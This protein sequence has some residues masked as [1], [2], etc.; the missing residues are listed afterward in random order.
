MSW[1]CR[2]TAH[3]PTRTISLTTS[4]LKRPATERAKLLV[5]SVVCRERVAVR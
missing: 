3:G 5:V 4:G 1:R 2:A